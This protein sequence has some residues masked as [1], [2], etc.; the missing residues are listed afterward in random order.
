MKL[1]EWSEGFN[2]NIKPIDEQH[3]QMA[4][5]VNELYSLLGTNKKEA[6]KY[7]IKKLIDDV[8][9]HFD[10]EEQLMKSGK[11]VNYFSHKL[12]HDRFSNEMKSFYSNYSRG[13]ADISLE[14][15]NKIK[16]WMVNHIEINDR[17]LG[18]FLNSLEN[19]DELLN[20]IESSWT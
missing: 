2:V 12:E 20:Q 14:F 15:L 1:I 11:F 9:I 3:Q 16:R 18:S 4:K 5:T 7:L 17:K 10:T 13:Q 6:K 8:K 19:R